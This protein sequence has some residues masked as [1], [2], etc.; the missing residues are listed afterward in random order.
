MESKYGLLIIAILFSFML[1]SCTSTQSPEAKGDV[2]SSSRIGGSGSV[3]ISFVDG[4]PPNNIYIDPS[5]PSSNEFEFIVNI[6]NRGSFP[7]TDEGSLNGKLYL[8]GY[9]PSL[10]KGG[11]WQGAG[12]AGNQFNRL[13]GVSDSTPQGET[14]Q[15]SFEADE[16]VYPFETRE[17]PL[18]L[19]LNACYYYETDA[20]ATVCIDP[21]PAM[22]KD[23]VCTQGSPMIDPHNAPVV[24]AGITQTGTSEK[25]IFTI[26][27]SA[28]SN[29][30]ILKAFQPRDISRELCTNPDYDDFDK[31][32]VRTEI[33][34]LGEGNCRPSGSAEEPIRIYNGRATIVCEFP[35]PNDQQN[36]YTTQMKIKL[37]YGITESMTKSVTLINTAVS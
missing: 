8:T 28:R 5:Q 14:I 17:Y 1:S 25:S 29:G 4:F 7:K 10:I 34:G 11:D 36:A 12:D 15:K 31:I 24:V 30:R 9:D 23:K 32:G 6:Q 33:T 21:D 27:L 37:Q 22:Q 26:D 19:M 16:I 3:E 13:R 35:V 20:T 18:S 2:P